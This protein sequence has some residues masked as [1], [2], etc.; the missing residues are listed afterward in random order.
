MW[1][2]T[3]SLHI[4]VVA[5]IFITGC[6]SH[7]QYKN[8]FVPLWAKDAVFYQIFPERFANGD[9]TNDPEGKVAWDAE[10]TQS[11]YFGGDIQGIINKL[12]YLTELGINAIYLNPIF[13][14]NT[15]HKY[16]TIDYLKI[17]R[18]FGTEETFLKFLKECHDRNIRVIIDG[19]FNHT[20]TQFFAFKDIVEKGEKSK[21]VNWY[22]IHSFPVKLPPEKPNY[23]AWWGIGE[24]PKLMADNQ[25]VKKYLFDVSKYW[26]EKGIDGW[27]L[28]VPN[29]MSHQF[30]KDW[31]ILIKQTNLEAL[32]IGEI[33]NDA[34][35][36]LQGDQ[37]DAVMNYR[38]RGACVGFIALKNKS[39]SQFDSI[40][41]EIRSTYKEEVNF[42]LQNL[43]SSHDTERFLTLSENDTNKLKLAVLMQM[44]YVGSPMI[45]YGDEIG[46]TG[47]KDPE[48]RRTM[49]WDKS[50]W[51]MGL[52]N[53]FRKLIQIRNNNDIFRKG[54]IESL[55][56]DDS[57]QLYGFVRKYQNNEAVIF[58]NTNIDSVSVPY[59]IMN[60]NVKYYEELLNGK[61]YSMNELKNDSL[62]IAPQS[63]MIFIGKITE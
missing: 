63:G 42:A 59:S 61:T 25:E 35:P 12:D 36:W 21:Y 3:V 14:S 18:H 41:T 46:M 54:S 27:R 7:K 49:K 10:P 20:G 4:A 44:T 47:G 15:N 22:S 57:L 11:N 26:T 8:N 30:W 33:W 43:I 13:E 31:R 24:L 50:K 19:V 29:E 28:D 38:F 37:F 52:W 53:W 45:Y 56:A 51:N 1:I 16:H 23:E 58:I 40:L 48:C 17:D 39:A 9:T 62:R 55:I 2:R 34:I 32:I 60:K 5:T 6:D